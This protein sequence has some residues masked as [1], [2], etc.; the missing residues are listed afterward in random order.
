LIPGADY[1]A[2]LERARRLQRTAAQ[3]GLESVLELGLRF[4]LTAP[5]VSTVLVGL[6]DIEHLEAAIRWSERG[7]LPEDQFRLL[8]GM[9]Q[10]G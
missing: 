9:A 5:G 4:A 3:L 6:S 1:D 10:T 2:D 7:A 8:V